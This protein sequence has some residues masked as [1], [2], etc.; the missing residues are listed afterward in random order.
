[1]RFGC[2][3]RHPVGVVVGREVHERAAGISLYL[4]G[5]GL[6]NSLKGKRFRS[7]LYTKQH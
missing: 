6:A 4:R 7:A 2:H 3:E 5:R 1:V